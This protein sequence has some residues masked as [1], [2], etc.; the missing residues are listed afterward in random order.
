M[1][2]TILA[3]VAFLAI[4]TLASARTLPPVADAGPNMSAILDTR[5]Q[6]Y[7]TATDPNGLPIVAWSWVVVSAPVGLRYA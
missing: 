5:I 2:S 7:G 3:L 4:P 6:L 1:K